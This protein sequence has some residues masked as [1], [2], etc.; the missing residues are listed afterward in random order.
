MKGIWVALL[1]LSSGCIEQGIGVSNRT[2]EA[3]ITSHKDGDTVLEGQVVGVRG[4]VQDAETAANELSV[5]WYVGEQLM[6]SDIPSQDGTTNC[7]LSLSEGDSQVLLEV[8]DVHG[9]I[10]GD[11]PGEGAALGRQNVVVGPER[12]L[13]SEQQRRRARERSF[14]PMR[15]L[16]SRALSPMK[17]MR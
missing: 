7:N 1:F 9:A 10:G 11:A 16:S 6:C 5:S 12:R 8:H 15:R 2:P 3:E 13:A 14:T 17:K 4:R